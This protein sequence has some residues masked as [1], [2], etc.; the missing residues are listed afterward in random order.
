M[1]DA[2]A[3][4]SKTVS[5][6]VQFEGM[7]GCP[8]TDVLTLILRDCD[9]VCYVLDVTAAD[10]IKLYLEIERTFRSTEARRRLAFQLAEMGLGG[11]DV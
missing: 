9:G 11:A 1:A 8:E 2:A 3:P 6:V 5:A 10:A 4:D 7:D